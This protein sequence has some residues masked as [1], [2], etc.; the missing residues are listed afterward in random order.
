MTIWRGT[1]PLSALAA[2]CCH[3]DSC[4]MVMGPFVIMASCSGLFDKGDAGAVTI[5]WCFPA[6][7]VL[8][9]SMLLA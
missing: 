7:L 2:C 8:D 5:L 4:L 1:V 9:M 6:A 3:V